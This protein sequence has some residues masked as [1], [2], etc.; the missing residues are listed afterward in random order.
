MEL[1]HACHGIKLPFAVLS[2]PV[3][4]K[5]AKDVP[6]KPRKLAAIFQQQEEFLVKSPAESSQKREFKFFLFSLLIKLPVLQLSGAYFGAD[7]SLQPKLR[8]FEHR[9]QANSD[10]T[11]C[12]FMLNSITAREIDLT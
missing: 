12:S 6:W 5:S 4:P 10:T 2:G 8:N 11:N 1:S 9:I 7:R 3:S